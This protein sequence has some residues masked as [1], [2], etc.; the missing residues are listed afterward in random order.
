MKNSSVAQIRKLTIALII[1][2]T[3][4]IALAG[5]FFY[6]YA[7]EQPPT[8]YFE[9]KPAKIEKQQ[10]TLTASPY[11]NKLINQYKELSFETLKGQLNHVQ[12]VEALLSKREIALACLSAFHHLDLE[13]FLANHPLLRQKRMTIT[14]QTNRGEQSTLYAYPGLNDKH[15]KEIFFFLKTERWPFKSKGLFLL[16]QKEPKEARD[17]TLMD[18][19]MM[20]SEFLSAEL[21]FARAEYPTDKEE[22]LNMLLEGTWKQLSSFAEQQ[23][24]AQ[25]LSPERRQRF[26]IDYF[27][28]GSKIAMYYLDREQQKTKPP[29]EVAEKKVEIATIGQKKNSLPSELPKTALP[30][31][32]AEKKKSITSAKPPPLTLPDKKP[33]ISSIPHK[34]PS[35]LKKQERTYIV[36]EGDSLWK[37]SKKF[38]VDIDRLRAYNQLQTDALKPGKSLRIPS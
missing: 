38:N 35:S 3:F 25:D 21:L 37:I 27:E 4:N 36:Q 24:I 20:T 7:R 31:P 34:L 15:F 32:V 29:L 28:N 12:V 14:Y 18:A 1:S 23:K 16:L 10:V 2:G 30:P 13:R 6:W 9:L 22:L 17:A 5:L 26:L 11:M 33:L 19:F 8:P